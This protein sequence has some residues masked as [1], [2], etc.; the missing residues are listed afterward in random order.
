MKKFERT[1][2]VYRLNIDRDLKLDNILMS[3]DSANA[4]IKISD[5]GLSTICHL[6]EHYDP[7]ESTKRKGALRTAEYFTPEFIYSKNN[8]LLLVHYLL[9]SICINKNDNDSKNLFLFIVQWQISTKGFLLPASTPYN[10]SI[11]VSK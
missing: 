2:D 8:I 3:S 4:D 1:L 10:I 5:F 7:E 6:C 11:G 9:I